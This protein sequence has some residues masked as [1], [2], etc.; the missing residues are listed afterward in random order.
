LFGYENDVGI[1][2]LYISTAVNHQVFDLL[3]ISNGD[4]K[5]Y[6]W[7]KNFNRLL[8]LRTVKSHNSMHYCKRCLRGYRTIESLNIH[9]KYCLQHDAQRI[10]LPKPNTKTKFKNYNRSMRVPI[11]IYADFESFI[12]PISTCQ[13]DPRKSYTNKYQKHVTCSFSYKIVKRY[14][15]YCRR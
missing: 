1:Y 14:V 9:N 2:P 4:K 13:S 10:E 8:S 11:V 7:I 3:L 5:H 12:K 15:F 6:C